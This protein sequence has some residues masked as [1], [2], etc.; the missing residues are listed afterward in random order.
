MRIT[1]FAPALKSV[2]S[3]VLTGSIAPLNEAGQEGEEGG[4]RM[5]LCVRFV[6]GLGIAGFV[7]GGMFLS[8]C[9]VKLTAPAA[10]AQAASAP[11]VNSI[12]VEGNRRVEAATVRSYFKPG[13]S[14]RL[15]AQAIDDAYKSLT[16]LAFSRMSASARPAAISW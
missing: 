3:G 7:L 15:D 2:R 8:I 11:A 13:P 1:W 5:N 12:V 9:A 4:L 14:G 6:R 10:H 16:Q